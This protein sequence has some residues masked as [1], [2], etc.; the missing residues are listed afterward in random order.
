MGD[1]GCY[2]LDPAALPPLRSGNHTVDVRSQVG[3]FNWLEQTGY[4]VHL[5][6]SLGSLVVFSVVWT[7]DGSWNLMNIGKT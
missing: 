3:V 6:P 5:N 2:F 4:L 7:Q 1:L